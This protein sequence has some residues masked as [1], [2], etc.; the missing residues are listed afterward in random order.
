MLDDLNELKTFRAILSAGSLSAAARDLGTSLAVVS[1]RLVSLERRVGVRLIHRST[2]TLAPT[3]EGVLLIFDIERALDAIAA[4]EERLVGARDEPAGTLRVSAP[5]SFGRRH[6]APVLGQLAARYPRLGIALT[7]DDRL[8]DL[9][10]DGLD[11]VVRIGEVTDSS[12]VMRRLADNH[13]VLVAAPVYLDRTGRPTIPDQ[14][15]DPVHAFL[16]Y[17]D[18]TLPWRLT[19]P[20]GMTSSLK[21]PGRFRVNNGDAIHDWALAGQGIMLKSEIDVAGDVAAGRLERVL[22][23]WSGG[24]APIVAL[25]PTTRHLPLKTRAFLDTMAAQLAAKP[26]A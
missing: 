23:E 22:P 9:V 14:L 4:G 18:S 11:V 19:G 10:G 7:L 8:A 5:V 13:R 25:F 15:E 20:G 24:Q 1:K 17:G 2:R 21:A 26:I 6:V 16:R 12:V 3:D